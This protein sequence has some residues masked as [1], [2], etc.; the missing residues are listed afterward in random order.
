MSLKDLPQWQIF[1][2]YQ[3]RKP[4]SSI[5]ENRVY[6]NAGKY[7]IIVSCGGDGTLH[8]VANGVLKSGHDT[9]VG[10][11]PFG[12]CNDVARTLG[13]PTDLNLAIDC[14]LRLNTTKYDVATDGS[15]YMIYSL[16]GGYLTGTSYEA[17]SK[18]KRFFGKMAY[19]FNALKSL[20]KFKSFPM[21]FNINGERVHGKF[22]FF[23]MLNGESAGGFR[24]NKGEDLNN[25]K[26]KLILIKKS[27]FLGSLF[28]MLKL[29]L[30]GVKNIKKSKNIILRDVESVEIENHS[31]IPFTFDGEKFKFLRKKFVVNKT[32][33]F[34]KK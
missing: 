6:K 33:N 7:D 32:L 10:V 3:P 29:F 9:I 12:T 13:I 26:V 15:D 23:M 11:L 8:Q 2:V 28:S 24:L 17:S 4:K 22:K 5:I 25:G 31:N 34:I 16:A 20:F 14:I 30:F 18:S 19:V 21:T 1:F 27:K